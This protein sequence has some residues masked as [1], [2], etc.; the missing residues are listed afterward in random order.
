MLDGY[1]GA[2]ERRGADDAEGDAPWLG[3][4]SS[5]TDPGPSGSAR[6]ADVGQEP[7]EGNVY[8]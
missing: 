7:Q 1:P 5:R 3:A 4:G 6:G 8:P 2:I